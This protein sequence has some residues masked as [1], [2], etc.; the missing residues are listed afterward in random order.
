MQPAPAADKRWFMILALILQVQTLIL[1]C[2]IK[3]GVLFLLLKKIKSSAYVFFS[4]LQ[5]T[6]WILRG[7]VKPEH[8]F[9]LLEILSGEKE[10]LL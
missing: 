1:R 7:L 2:N 3:L 5:N 8:T 6:N 4:S 9:G 10:E